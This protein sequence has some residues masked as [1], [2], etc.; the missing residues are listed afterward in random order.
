MRNPA[1]PWV[2]AILF[3]FVLGGGLAGGAVQTAARLSQGLALPGGPLAVV[4]LLLTLVLIGWAARASG[5]GRADA[6]IRGAL[7]AGAAFSVAI[8]PL[9]SVAALAPFVDAARAAD[10]AQAGLLRDLLQ[11][12]LGRLVLADGLGLPLVAAL[13][14]LIAGGVAAPPRGAATPGL[15]PSGGILVVLG[16]VVVALRIGFAAVSRPLW[17]QGWLAAAPILVGVGVVAFGLA[18]ARGQRAG[19]GPFDRALAYP[20]QSQA[21]DV[22]L[23]LLCAWGASGAGVNRVLGLLVLPE[24]GLLVDPVTAL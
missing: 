7:L 3:P 8:G 1:L 17:M 6:A 18:W 5:T 9:L 12:S 23:A 14:A 22:V 2:I 20:S 19:S 16:L 15:R 24:L 13:G 4:L 10:G 11:A 21:L